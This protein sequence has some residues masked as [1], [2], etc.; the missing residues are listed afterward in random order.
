MA[1]TVAV[2]MRF[3]LVALCVCATLAAGP[4]PTDAD[5]SSADQSSMLALVP[6]EQAS[7]AVA[8]VPR[9]R[10]R[11][12]A[13][14]AAAATDEVAARALGEWHAGCVSDY[15]C[16]CVFGGHRTLPRH[17]G[18]PVCTTRA[19]QPAHPLRLWLCAAV[20]CDPCP[21][22]EYMVQACAGGSD[23]TPQCAR[24]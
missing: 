23:T 9:L 16:A 7:T 6:P 5:A 14:E 13:M 11:R 24:T 19:T 15:V 21:F 12:A 18:G 1:R 17:C 22:G 8:T 10:S 20:G 4:A 3:A 2:V